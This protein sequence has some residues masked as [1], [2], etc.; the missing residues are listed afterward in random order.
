MKTKSL[1]EPKNKE[2]KQ[3]SPPLVLS[4]ISAPKNIKD[5]KRILSKLIS[6]FIKGEIEDQRAKTLCYLLN[7]FVMIVRD[8]DF[9]TRLQLLESNMKSD[10]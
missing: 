6:A 10:K 3:T 7:S 4:G 9:E 8:N 5:A 1:Q 2:V